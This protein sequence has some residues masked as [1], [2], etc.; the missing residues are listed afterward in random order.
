MGYK[1]SKRSLDRLDG[2]HPLLIEL[3][4]EAIKES[5]HDFGIP[6]DGGL[7]T[8]QR[9][10]ELYAIG[11]TIEMG[12]K[13][14]TKVDGVNR[15]SR[16]QMKSDGHGHAFDIYIYLADQKRA[17]WDVD[18]LTEVAIHILKVA[19]RMEIA[20]EWGGNWKWKDLPHFQL[21]DL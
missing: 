5:P 8:T 18:M 13:P 3:V 12:R 6:R 15:K 7:R 21:I 17:S 10:Q 4:Q 20:L 19:Q 2:V 1:L 11:R 14:V 9:Q 16:H